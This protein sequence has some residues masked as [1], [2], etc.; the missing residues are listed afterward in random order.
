MQE[1]TV[2]VTGGAGYIGSHTCKALK[3]GGFLPVTYDNLS[4]GHRSFVKWGPLCFGDLRDKEALRRTFSVYQPIAVLHFAAD[5][6]VIESM[7]NPAKY[8]SN[9][10]TSS[11]ALLE[12]MQEYKTPYLVF[13]SSCATYGNPNAPLITETHPQAPINPYG[14]SKWMVEQIIEDFIEIH[15]LKAVC[16]RYF[17]AAGTDFEREVGEDHH[18]ETHLIPL[19]IQT[20]LEQRSE[21]IVYGDDFPT[22]DGSAVRDYIHVEDLAIGHVKALHH[23]LNGGKS[24]SINLGTGTG[25]S[26]FEL[27]EMVERFAEKKIPFRVE[28]QR[29][30]EPSH[31]VASNE[32]AKQL[33][34]WTPLYSSLPTIIESAWNWHSLRALT[35]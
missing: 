20:A 35:R 32:K 13:S 25:Y 4:T 10:V 28:K 30:G 29:K 23:L 5:A 11:I 19:I 21:L 33:L 17:N 14:K 7:H 22:K 2:L 8:Y 6:I 18:P 31:L 1:Q 3:K 24:S 9:N 12:V 34:N 27:I 26:V 16:L 15:H